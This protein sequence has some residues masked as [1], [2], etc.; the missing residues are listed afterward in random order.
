VFRSAEAA[1]QTLERRLERASQIIQ[2]SKA[3]DG[4][5]VIVVFPSGAS[6]F[7]RDGDVLAAINAPT[8]EVALEFEAASEKPNR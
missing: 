1:Q 2:R 8:V 3:L 5:R 4:E 7:R 6:I